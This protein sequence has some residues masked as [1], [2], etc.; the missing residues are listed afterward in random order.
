[1]KLRNYLEDLPDLKAKEA[2][3]KRCETTWGFLKL[4]AY[5]HR[6][7]GESLAINI[8]RE[9]A[10]Q[11]TCEELRPDVDWAYLRQSLKRAAAGGARAAR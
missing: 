4:V 2:F 1:M 3:A 6:R 7:A 9:S 10:G 11:V 5:G 8:D